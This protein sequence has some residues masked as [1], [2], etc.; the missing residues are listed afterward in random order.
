MSENSNA[1]HVRIERVVD[2]PIETVW[3]MWA[4]PEHFAAWYGPMG[5]T[6]PTAEMDVREGGRRFIKM[7][8][9]TPNGPMEMFFVG[10]Y[11]EVSAPSRRRYSESVADADGNPKSPADMGMPDGHPMETEVVVE[12]EAD[13]ER[14]RMVLSHHGVP[15]DSPGGMGWKMALD[16][17]EQRLA[18]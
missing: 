14:T 16:K 7:A 8:M 5:A 6:I 9:D 17:L 1:D 13:G 12:L 4:D 3:Q 2:A 11:R 18:G 15:A 10:E